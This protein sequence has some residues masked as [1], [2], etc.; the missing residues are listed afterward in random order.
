[1]GRFYSLLLIICFVSLNLTQA[2]T[3]TWTGNGDNYFWSDPLNWDTGT[4]PLQNG[5]GTVIIPTGAVVHSTSLIIFKQGLFTGGGTLDNDGGLYIIHDSE[6]NSTKVFENI[7]IEMNGQTKI[8]KSAG[9]SNNEP[10]Y[11]N[12]GAILH[13]GSQQFALEIENIS[14]TYSTT[15][16]GKIEVYSPFVKNGIEE[17]IIDVEM[18]ICCYD[19]EVAEGTLIIESRYYNNIISPDLFIAPTASLILSGNNNFYYPNSSTIEGTVEGYFEIRSQNSYNPSIGGT[20]FFEIEGTVYFNNVVFEGNGNFFNRA[21]VII[22]ENSNISFDNIY[23]SNQ[24]YLYIEQNSTITLLNNGSIGNNSDSEIYISDG[25]ISGTNNESF[26]NGGEITI[27]E[28][29]TYSLNNINF[30]NSG[31]LDIG[32]GEFILDDLSNFENQ[33][34]YDPF[35]LKG[36]VLG[37]GLFKF[38]AFGSSTVINSGYFSPSPGATTL[39]TEN[40]SQS[41]EGFYQVDINS[42]TEYDIISN[43]G[44]THFEGDFEVTLNF[45]P[46]IGDEFEVFVSDSPLTNCQPVTTTSANY[47]GFTYVFDVICNT[48]SIILKLGTI[49]NTEYFSKE[50]QFFTSPNPTNDL[51]SF[52]YAPETLQQNDTLHI[53][54]YSP[55]G[56][57]VEAISVVS[58]TSIFETSHLTSGVYIAMLVSEKGVL[59]TTKISVK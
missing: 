38:P 5:I 28:N 12:E 7:L 59:A 11:I 34:I 51:I 30:R 58:E 26:I 20:L 15:I 40:F 1:M 54:I 35:Y 27:L 48:S 8:F 16:P 31:L 55:L 2:Q 57:K 22:H 46:T 3:H 19:F 4:V 45:A 47:D 43:S 36:I 39:N 10:I 33:F 21:T 18:I 50:T 49:L 9:I 6:V 17:V 42:L 52:E 25:T 37:S 41:P 56:Q 53:E 23:F 29:A 14:I 32:N 24:E 44:A 13:T